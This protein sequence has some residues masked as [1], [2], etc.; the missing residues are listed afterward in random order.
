MKTVFKVGMEV[1]DQVFFGD[2]TL[3]IIE[4]RGDMSLRVLYGEATYCYTGDGRFIGDDIISN[5][6]NCISQIPTLSTSPYT[7]QGFE[8]KA[9]V[10]T[11][12]E[13]V[14][15]LEKNSKDRV[16]YADEAYINEEYERAFEA[17]KKLTILRD[18]YNEG[19]QPDW[20]KKDK[21][22]CIEYEET[23]ISP[24]DHICNSRIMTFKNPEIRDKFLEEQKDLLE[25]A[26]LLL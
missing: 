23:S 17:L 15:W 16:I 24:I 14:E 11:Y 13:A 19:W 26:K 2:E 25:T 7:L 18:Y 20:S 8:Q 10:R 21:K 4:V 12:E 3:K 6:W 5:R 9:P 1:Y 22:Y